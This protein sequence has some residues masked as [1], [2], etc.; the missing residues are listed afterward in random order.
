VGLH[1][2]TQGWGKVVRVM[3]KPHDSLYA[4]D[5]GERRGAYAYSRAENL[6]RPQ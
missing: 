4:A 3:S 2:N 6:G 1:I 5:N